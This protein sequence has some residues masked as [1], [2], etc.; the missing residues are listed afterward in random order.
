MRVLEGEKSSSLNRK[1]HDKGRNFDKS[2][3]VS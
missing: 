2:F 3:D 1:Q